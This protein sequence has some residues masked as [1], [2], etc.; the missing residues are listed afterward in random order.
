VTPETFATYLRWYVVSVVA[1]DPVAKVSEVVAVAENPYDVAKINVGSIVAPVPP[2][3]LARMPNC[4]V[5]MVEEA[6]VAP[7]ALIVL[8]AFC[9]DVNV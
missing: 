4:S 6:A 9:C 3:E 2:V 5:P 1:L 8:D 7:I